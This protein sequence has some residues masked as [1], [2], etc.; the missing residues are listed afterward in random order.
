MASRKAS[1]S[2]GK[3]IYTCGLFGCILHLASVVSHVSSFIKYITGS[4]AA[5]DGFTKAGLKFA[6]DNG[7]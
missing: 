3:I 7:F 2:T 6:L 1:L 4:T 5:T